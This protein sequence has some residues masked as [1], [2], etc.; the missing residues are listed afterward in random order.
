MMRAL[1]VS[2]LNQLGETAQQSDASGLHYLVSWEVVARA[3]NLDFQVLGVLNWCWF[4]TG[5][6]IYPAISDIDVNSGLY[7]L[8]R[9][10]LH[11]NES[12]TLGVQYQHF[13][14]GDLQS[15]PSAWIQFSFWA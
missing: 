7:V 13:F 6:A 14:G 15:I 11:A 10:A 8:P 9:V 3:N 2:K 1:S 12:F 5:I 4:L